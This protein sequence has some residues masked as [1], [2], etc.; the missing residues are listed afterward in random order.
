MR[1]IVLLLAS[2]ILTIAAAQAQ[3]LKGCK[4]SANKFDPNSTSNEFGRCGSPFSPDSINNKFGKFGSEFSPHSVNNPFATHAPKIES[5]DGTYLGRKSANKFDSVSTSNEFGSHGSRLSPT[6][7]NNP[8]SK[9]GSEFSNK[10]AKNPFA[11]D[12][13]KLEDDEK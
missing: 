11:T 6:S 4:L 7:I 1:R 2:F 5:S 12:A 10:S 9:Y 13:P 3:T 8:L